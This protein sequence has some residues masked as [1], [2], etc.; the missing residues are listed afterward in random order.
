MD[1]AKNHLDVGLMTTSIEA[2]LEFWQQ[3]VG[4]PVEGVLPLTATMV[5][6]RHG[7]NGSVFKLNHVKRALPA[8]A[9][10]GYRELRIARE[11]LAAARELRDPDGNRVTLV[12]KGA[13]GVTGIEIVLGVRSETAFH[14]F[15]G[16]VLGLEACGGNTYRCGD[17][18]LTFHADPT[19]TADPEWIGQGYRYLTVQVRDVEHEHRTALSRGGRQGA[20]PGNVGDVARI[21]FLLDPDGNWLEVSQRAS[22]TGP[23]PEPPGEPPFR[24]PE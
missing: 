24:L 4:L 12:P 23:L 13:N 11:G 3:S 20:A 21:S 18:R 10:T 15:L 5:Q 8:A 22:L 2:M 19:A 9:P 6:H 17:T 14:R 16:E 1:L 7:M